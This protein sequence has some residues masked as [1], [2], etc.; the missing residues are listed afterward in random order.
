M[1]HKQGQKMFSGKPH[2][3]NILRLLKIVLICALEWDKLTL[4]KSLSQI[5]HIILLHL[6]ETLES[7]GNW[8]HWAQIQMQHSK[9]I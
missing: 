2:K 8:V 9:Y 5:L 3:A 6:I 1:M 7:T 4:L